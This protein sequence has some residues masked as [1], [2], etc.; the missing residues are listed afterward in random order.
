M[1]KASR[2]RLIDRPYSLTE[3]GHLKLHEIRDHLVLMATLAFTSTQAEEDE[4][5]R[6]RRSALAECFENFSFQI[7]EVLEEVGDVDCQCRHKHA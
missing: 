3:D 6:L 4:P 1:K 7:D 5:L 2:P